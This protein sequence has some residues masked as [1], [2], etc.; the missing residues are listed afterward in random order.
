MDNDYYLPPDSAPK[1]LG[2]SAE[3]DGAMRRL[4]VHA[5]TQEPQVLHLLPHQP[6]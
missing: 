4:S 3:V 6:T 5:L 2:R 1:D